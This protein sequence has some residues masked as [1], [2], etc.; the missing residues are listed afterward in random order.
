MTESGFPAEAES[1]ERIGSWTTIG[2]V[3]SSISG[4]TFHA[5]VQQTS[6]NYFRDLIAA[7]ALDAGDVE[8]CRATFVEPPEFAEA[9][10]A[11]QRESVIA[12]LG[13]SGC[14]RRTTGT[15]L[16][17]TLGVTPKAV[18]LD[19]EDFGRQLEIAPGHGYLLDLDEDSEQLTTRAAPG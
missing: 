4:G 8:R 2:S 14:G 9:I 16:L 3:G 5:P 7:M 13:Q 6:Y 11:L 1:F 17:A 15:V 19:P 10:V 12:L 18:L